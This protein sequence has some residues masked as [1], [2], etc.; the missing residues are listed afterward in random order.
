[1][2]CESRKFFRRHGSRRI[3]P[4]PEQALGNDLRWRDWRDPIA[5][6]GTDPDTQT[7]ES[8]ENQPPSSPLVEATGW[9]VGTQGEI[10]LT[11]TAPNLIAP[12]SGQLPI[13]CDR[14]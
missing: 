3:A 14:S 13:Q 2:S 8:A 5:E 10:I 11:G 7:R 1:M 4:T 9:T 12:D 6:F